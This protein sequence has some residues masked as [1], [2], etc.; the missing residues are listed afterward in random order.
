MSTA[1]VEALQDLKA[2]A[3]TLVKDL[4]KAQSD[5]AT[6]S[7][8]RKMGP[9]KP[10][11]A[12]DG[13]ARDSDSIGSLDEP[14]SPTS[15][16][17]DDRTDAKT[18][19]ARKEEDTIVDY[20]SKRQAAQKH[21]ELLILGKAE[22]SNYQSRASEVEDT[23]YDDYLISEVMKRAQKYIEDVGKTISHSVPKAIV[24]SM[25]EPC[26][27]DILGKL[28]TAMCTSNP[29]GSVDTWVEEDTKMQA[30]REDCS[31]VIRRVKAARD[32][33]QRDRK[34]V[35]VGKECRSRWSPYH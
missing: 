13:S 11:N 33:V 28:Y 21:M 8:F 14:L 35:G 15:E 7:F 5:Y 29:E 16:A 22:R 12:A 20:F 31:N 4:I 3:Q 1:A 25:L 34:S 19:K 26:K 10:A 9:I 23:L 30:R 27:A 32:I 6:V 17:S 24:L 2:D 18:P